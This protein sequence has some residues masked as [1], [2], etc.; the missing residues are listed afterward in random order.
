MISI[1]IPVYRN[2]PGALSLVTALARQDLPADQGLEVL[3]VDD[4]S[5]DGTLQLLRQGTGN[6]SVVALPENKGRSGAIAAGIE[7]GSGDVLGFLD[8]DCRPA[9]ESFVSR[10]WACLAEGHVAS[11]GPIVAPGSGFWARYQ[12]DA[13]LRRKKQYARGLTWAGTTANFF[14]RR[15]ALMDAGGLSADYHQYGFEDR[16]LLLR[17]SRLG[18]IGWCDAAPL[19]HL[20]DIELGGI[21]NKMKEAGGSSAEVFSSEHPEAYRAL[22]YAA[23]DARLHP[24][25][26]PAGRLARPVFAAAGKIDSGVCSRWT[27][28]LIGKW[29]VKACVALAFMSGTANA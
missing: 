18:S 24:W 27:P 29:V 20:D 10:H 5:N 22:G 15:D 4:G 11:C 17:L 26:L 16:D 23:I 25:L 14:V 19:L 3:L 28:Y 8:C 6:A 21:L 9:E 7:K 2:A 1:V 13:S 12:I